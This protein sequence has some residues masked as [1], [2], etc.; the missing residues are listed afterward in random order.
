VAAPLSESVPNVLFDLH[1]PMARDQGRMGTKAAVL[2]T[3]AQAGFPVPVGRVIAADA[4]AGAADAV[5]LPEPVLAALR[6]IAESYGATPLAVRSSALAEDLP[7]SSFAGQYETVLDVRGATALEAAVRQCQASI[8]SASASAYRAHQGI[9]DRRPMAVLVQHLV[10]ADAAGVVLGADPITGDRSRALVSAVR[11]SGARL[12]SGEAEPEDWLVT[13]KATHCR[14]HRGVLTSDLARAVAALL[15]GVEAFLAPPMEIEWALADGRLFLLQARPMTALPVEADWP[16]P[17]PGAWFRGLRLGEWLP[18]PVTPLFETWLI[19]RMEERFRLRQEM[20]GGIRIP[21]PLHVLVHGWYFHSPIGNGRQTLLIRGLLR[22]PRFA[23]ATLLG[24]RRPD[25]AERLL[26]NGLTHRWRAEVLHPYQCLVADGEQRVEQSTLAELVRMVDELADSAGSFLWSLVLFGGAAWRSEVAL[27]RFYRR[28]LQPE[29]TTPYQVLLSALSTPVTPDHAVHSLDWV[30]ETLGELRSPER[31]EPVRTRNEGLAAERLAVESACLRALAHNPKRRERFTVLLQVARR[32]AALRD[33]HSAWFTLA[34]PL[35]R[36]CLRRLG[37]AL[38]RPEDLFFVRRAELDALLNTP[39]SAELTRKVGERR[40]EW[41]RQR[42]L[43]P[44]LLVGKPPFL[45]AKLLLPTPK[46][47][48]T[49]TIA[50]SRVLHGTPA[51]PGQATGSVHVLREPTAIDAVRPGDVL[52]VSAAVPALTPLFDRIAAL[53]VDS[54]GVAAHASLVA[55][56]YGVPAVTG[57]GDATN[58]LTDGTIAT[59]NGSTGTV[60]IH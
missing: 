58:R 15:E 28:H 18:E 26:F 43:C 21:A 34:W 14:R 11:G 4:F 1:D 50:R 8:H 51:S 60:E 54:G 25:L 35:M 40:A 44:P 10:E 7:H 59:V 47:L 57:L 19:E 27:A 37:T 33:E 55:R 41:E 42:R 30:R 46:F 52:V 48:R 39:A 53:C 16:A 2:A 3:L 24:S 5:P 20:V 49:P 6:Q 31:R 32:Q 22:R 23:L 17:L 56:E 13:S 9:D 12:V 38:D 45:L 36:R 29:L